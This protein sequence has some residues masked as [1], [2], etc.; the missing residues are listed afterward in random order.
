MLPF[1]PAAGISSQPA[2]YSGTHHPPEIRAI[3]TKTIRTVVGLK[4]RH[5]AT[6]EATPPSRR[7]AGLR[8]SGPPSP[9]CLRPNGPPCQWPGCPDQ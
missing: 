1:S 7:S 8:R 2:T 3:R 9:W 6:P 4:P 5:A